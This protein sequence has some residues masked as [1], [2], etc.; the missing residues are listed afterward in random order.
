M[1]PSTGG[2]MQHIDLPK[3]S[4]V[5]QIDVSKRKLIWIHKSISGL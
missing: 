1:L 4:I 5:D 2:Y 3:P